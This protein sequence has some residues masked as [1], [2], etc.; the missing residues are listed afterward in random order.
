MPPA[1]GIIVPVRNEAALLP[2]TVPRLLAATAADMVRI[3]W[4]CNG[5]T[6]NS[7]AIIRHIAGPHGEVIELPRPGKIGALQAGDTALGALFPRFYMDADS[8]IRPGDMA[9]LV[10]ALQSVDTELV[11]PALNYDVSQSSWLSARIA[12]CWLAL[13]HGRSIAFS[14][15]LGLTAAGRA[16]WDEWP[17]VTG[18][19]SFVAATIP[20]TRRR[21]IAG[22]LATSPAPADFAGWVRMRARWRRGEAELAA[23]S[24]TV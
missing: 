12:A 11:A 16:R 17:D 3:I 20:S 5:C 15:L 1:Y 4:V 9:P 23:R 18:D 10:Q 8:W 6:D 22:A 7:A 19:D 24:L 2:L 21:R 14:M 13:P